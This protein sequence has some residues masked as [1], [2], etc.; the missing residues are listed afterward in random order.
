MG[1]AR[2]VA[3]VV[4]RSDGRSPSRVAGVRG[5]RWGCLRRGLVASGQGRAFGTGKV[6]GVGGGL[7]PS[8]W[9]KLWSRAGVGGVAG[10]GA[11]ADLFRSFSGGIRRTT[12]R[13][14]W[15]FV[16]RIWLSHQ[17]SSCTGCVV[18]SFCGTNSFRSHRHI[19]TAVEPTPNNTVGAADQDP[20]SRKSAGEL[21]VLVSAH[22]I[23][24][25]GKVRH[26]GE[27]ASLIPKLS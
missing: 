9:C 14:G 7:S 23:R 21:C 18:E 13:S 25:A 8:L 2:G 11:G 5:F 19:G 3:L 10:S 6:M 17:G 20:P 24:T 15:C 16:S 12:N 22:T 26:P 4:V 27:P 1:G